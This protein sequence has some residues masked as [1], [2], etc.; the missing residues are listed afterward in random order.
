[1]ESKIALI[2]GASSGFGLLT[3]VELAKSG[4]TVVAT[5]R[6]LERKTRLEDAAR[7]AGVLALLDIRKIDITEYN[8]LPDAVA[9]ILRD[10]KRIDVLINNAGFAVGGFS[11]DVQLEELRQQLDTNFFGHVAMTKAV[12]P[13]MRQQKSGKIIMISSILGLTG[14]PLVGSYVASKFAL[15][16]W[17]E[18]LRMETRALGI[19]VVLVEPGSFKTDIWDRNVVIGKNALS[20]ASPNRD[21]SRHY[22]EHVQNEIP[23]ADARI[24]ARLIVR[25]AKTANPRLRYRVGSDAHRAYWLRRIL[26]WGLYE[27]LAVD[28]SRIDSP[29]PLA[30]PDASSDSR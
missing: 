9:E 26:P 13:C 6:N 14:N 24:V 1:M 5:M 12:L 22:V 15:E 19:K 18:T 2:T 7:E 4:Y 23:K 29:R 10:H 21:R 16:G 3:S 30:A 27:K 8:A 28:Q 25:I 20:D 11:E 17:S